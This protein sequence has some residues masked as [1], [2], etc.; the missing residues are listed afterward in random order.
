VVKVDPTSLKTFEK[1]SLKKFNG[2]TIFE[3][4][5]CN[6]TISS[7]TLLVAGQDYYLLDLL[8]KTT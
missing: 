2:V 8:L 4:R 3:Q 1:K 6:E 7:P 5:K